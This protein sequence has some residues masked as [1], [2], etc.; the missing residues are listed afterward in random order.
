MD[1]LRKIKSRDELKKLTNKLRE[2]GKKIIFTNGVFDILHRAHVELFYYAKSLGDILI[3]GVNEDDS[4]KRLKGNERPINR[5]EDRAY[6][7]ASLEP[8]DYVVGFNEDTPYELIRELLPH[9]IV[10]GGDYT[11]DQVVGKDIVEAQGGRVVIFPL[12]RGYSTTEIIK[13]IK[14]D[15]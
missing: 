5:F 2:E 14:K 4:V 8:V 3:V 7:I 9:I 6:L 13:R 15:P 10:K 1:P 11:P 12:Q